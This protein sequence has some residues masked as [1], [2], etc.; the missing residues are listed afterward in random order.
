M[1]M[2]TTYTSAFVSPGYTT[3]L[4]GKVRLAEDSPNVTIFTKRQSG[5]LLTPSYTLEE[6]EMRRQGKTPSKEFLKEKRRRSMEAFKQQQQVYYD[7]A[8]SIVNEQDKFLETLN[9]INQ[10]NKLTGQPLIKAEVKYIK[11]SIEYGVP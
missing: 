5:D 3:T 6:L 1:I 7:K 4:P 8:N 11:S 10:I 2:G 9:E